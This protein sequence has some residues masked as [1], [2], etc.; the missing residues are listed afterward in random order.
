[1]WLDCRG[2]KTFVK[3]WRF[4][5]RGIN[6]EC[7]TCIGIPLRGFLFNIYTFNDG[8]NSF[9]QVHPLVRSEC[10]IFGKAGEGRS[11]PKIFHLICTI[12]RFNRSLFMI[13]KPKQALDTKLGSSNIRH[14]V[15]PANRIE[16][17]Y[18]GPSPKFSTF[19]LFDN[20]LCD[21]CWRISPCEKGEREEER[22]GKIYTNKICPIR[23]PYESGTQHGHQ[24]VLHS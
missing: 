21:K 7:L 6:F 1:M 19:W 20:V 4:S 9:L 15:P 12:T 23:V 3:A 2:G 5:V 8:R 14:A 11:L 24:D 17:I 22:E 13:Y 10:R 16:R 18:F